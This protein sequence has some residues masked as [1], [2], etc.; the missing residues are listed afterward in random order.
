MHLK[1]ISMRQ[2]AI[3][4]ALITLGT[5]TAPLW[6]VANGPGLTIFSGVAGDKQ[7][8]YRMDF[9]GNPNAWDRYRLY[10]PKKKMKLA[11]AQFVIDYPNYFDGKF[12][13]KSIEQKESCR[14]GSQ[15]G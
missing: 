6:A 4:L 5:V 13:P 12:D 14:P 11:V 8:N 3:V 2:S 15:M 1:K 7:L 9:G 10:I